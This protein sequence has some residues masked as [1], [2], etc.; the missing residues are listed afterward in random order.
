MPT[1]VLMTKLSPEVTRDMKK[2]EKI[3]REWKDEIDQKCPGIRW[4]DHY[5]L[6][7]PYDFMDI[8]EAPD[9]ETAAKVSMISLCRGA[10]QAESWTA[11]P[12]ARFVELTKQI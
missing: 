6:L 9:A 3:G 12:Y 4:I 11:I 10:L 8:F 5:A 2:R 7:G 1:F